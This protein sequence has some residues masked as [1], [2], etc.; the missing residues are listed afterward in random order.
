[1]PDY[2]QNHDDVVTETRNS[3]NS[4]SRE[5]A[6]DLEATDH[7]LKTATTTTRNTTKPLWPIFPPPRALRSAPLPRTALQR[8][9]YTE[10]TLI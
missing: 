6:F 7:S 5:K 8:T 2:F 9:Q 1:M 10:T 4:H 3:D